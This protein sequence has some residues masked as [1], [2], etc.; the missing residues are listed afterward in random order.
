MG[1]SEIVFSG[2][3]AMAPEQRKTTY[4]AAEVAVLEETILKQK[5]EIDELKRKLEHMNEIFANAQRARFGQSSEQ[6][7]YVLGKDQLSLFNEAESSQDHKAEE[8][9]PNT[10]FVEAHERK[11]KRSQTEMLNNLPEEEV[12]LE[13]PEGQLVCGKCGG[14]MKPIGKKFLRHEMQIVPKQIKLLAYYAVTYA[15]DSCEKDTGLAHIVSV[16]P[17]IPLMKHSLASPSTVAYIMTQKYVDGLPLARQEKIWAREGVSLSRATMANW[18]IQCSEV[19]LKPLYRHMKQEL[20]T[21]SVIHADETVVQ[22]LKEDGK[23]A[24][25]ESRMWL[26]ASAALL[27]HQVRLFE[28]QPD[29]SGKRPESFLKGFEGALVTDGYAGYN[30]VQKV[31]HCGCWAHARRKWREA[32]PD[33]ATVKTS[34]AA[35]GFRYC[36]QLFA[37]ERK[38]VLYKPEYRKEYRQGKELPLLEE[39]FAWLNTVHP[40]KGS[41]L[42]EAVRYSINQKQQLCAFLDKVEVP[43]SNNLAENAIRPFTL[44][45]KNWLFCDTPKGAKASA[46]V[47][48]LVE[49]A[50]ANGIEPFAYLQHVLVQLPYLGKSPSHEELET[51]MPWAPDIQQEYK[52]PNSDAYEK[53]YLD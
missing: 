11:K 14:K 22:V 42:E 39:Y 18:V 31:T 28:Y 32:M 34:K 50:K 3:K 52:M 23:P 24:T 38:C 40:E 25:S 16:K 1:L 47:Y 33:G 6:K 20:L 27:R 26:Y 9:N 17:P 41:K 45:R 36:N 5:A 21:H 48:S 12:L 8:P 44:G 19:W 4:T 10:I 46:I 35:I 51:L 13:I 49:S 53:C 2:G 43:I 37:E 29:R 30:Q 15:C 7:N